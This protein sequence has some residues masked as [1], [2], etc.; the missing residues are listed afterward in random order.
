MIVIDA[1]VAVKWLI[2]EPDSTSADRLLPRYAGAIAAPDLLLIETAGALVRQCNTGAFSAPTFESVLA[3]WQLLWANF[4][5]ARRTD[6]SDMVNAARMAVELG[7]PVKDCVYL[8]LA[9]ELDAALVTADAK[10]RSR[11][12]RLHPRIELLDTLQ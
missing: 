3:E 1:S 7:H 6:L 2:D 5:D 10:F 11:A 12:L 8:G 4:I 9:I